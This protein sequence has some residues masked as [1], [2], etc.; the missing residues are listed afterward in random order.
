IPENVLDAVTA[1]EQVELERRE[2]VY[3]AQRPPLEVRHRSVVVIDDGLATGSSMRAAVAA[4]RQREPRSIVVAVPVAAPSTCESLR[5]EVEAM[6]CVIMP[7]P[8]LGV[9]AWY[10]DFSQTSDDEVRALLSS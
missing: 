7:E 6:V 10:T 8:F 2:R 9:G 5:H 3:R 4:L 1:T